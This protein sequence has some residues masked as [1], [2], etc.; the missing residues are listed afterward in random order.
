MKNQTALITGASGGIGYEF[1]KLLAR[2]C[3]TLVL[4]ARN[5]GRLGDV[6]KELERAF[7]VSVLIM[8]KDLSKAGAP[9]EIFRELESR[10]I[11]VDIL[12]NN[13]GFGDLGAFA[14][15][16]WPKEEK[17]IAVNVTALT[18]ITKLFLKGMVERK[19]GRIVNVASTAAFQPGPFM[20]V[21]YAT[22]AY[23][24][25]FSE[26]LAC[27]LKGTGVSVTALCPGP[28][29]TGFA[30]AAEVGQSRLFRFVKPASATAV[31]RT[32]Y[33]A[34]KKGKPV[35]IH[36]FLNKFMAFSVRTAPRNLLP[37]IVRWLH[38]SNRAE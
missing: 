21:Y 30:T 29:A 7:P 14:E 10:K 1:A 34:M 25:S 11:A 22:K 13:A 38:E 36:G 37:I 9:E 35:V 27:E 26:A 19:S 15:T 17:M 23:V 4:V 12:I 33:D 3:S 24:L 16:E 5:E 31:A 2:D 18:R 8:G 20:S 32:G 6:K 28:T